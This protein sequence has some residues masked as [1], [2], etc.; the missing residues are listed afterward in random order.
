MRIWP[1]IFVT[2]IAASLFGVWRM[3]YFDEG[4]VFPF[5]IFGAIFFALAFFFKRLRN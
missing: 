3:Q 4:F 1:E 2:L 5:M